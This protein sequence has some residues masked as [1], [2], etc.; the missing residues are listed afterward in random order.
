MS[1]TEDTTILISLLERLPFKDMLFFF[2]EGTLPKIK[3]E[4]TAG[5]YVHIESHPDMLWINFNYLDRKQDNE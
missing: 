4:E 2:P 3:D 5:M 1:Y